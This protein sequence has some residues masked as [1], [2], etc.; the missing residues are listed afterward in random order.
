MRVLAAVET[1][2]TNAQD[3]RSMEMDSCKFHISPRKLCQC[4]RTVRAMTEGER[5]VYDEALRKLAEERVMDS[6]SNAA[7]E[8]STESDSSTVVGTSPHVDRGTPD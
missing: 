4:G 3:V 2:Q 6:E 7:T 1:G 8:E 5:E